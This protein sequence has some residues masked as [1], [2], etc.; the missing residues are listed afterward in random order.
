LTLVLDEAANVAPLPDLP[1]LMSDGGGRGM[2]TWTFVQ[3]FSQLRAR[4][5]RDG[6]DTIWGASS[7]KLLLG[8][9]TETDDLERVSRL[10][11]DRWVPRHSHTSRSGLIPVGE[12]STSTSRERER[13]LPVHDLARLP[14]G[15]ALLLYRSMPPALIQLPGWWQRPDADQFR[16]SQTRAEPRQEG[17]P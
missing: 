15:T 13:V 3:S 14:M 9:C 1:L 6:A 5:G 8:G 16:T 10:V 12:H 2:T 11:G 17:S 7:A 4:W